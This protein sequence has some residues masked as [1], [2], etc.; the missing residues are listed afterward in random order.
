MSRLQLFVAAF[1]VTAA[2]WLGGQ[3]AAEA[4]SCPWGAYSPETGAVGSY[5]SNFQNCATTNGAVN[6]AARVWINS[7]RPTASARRSIWCD[8]T[9]NVG[10]RVYAETVSSFTG[11]FS[12][13][14]IRGSANNCSTTRTTGTQFGY[15][16]NRAWC[17]VGIGSACTVSGTN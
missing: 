9:S 3:N 1:A 11:A 16:V 15:T 4:Q 12:S 10:L 7:S 14:I 5:E 13:R 2:T 17:Q 8:T 6:F